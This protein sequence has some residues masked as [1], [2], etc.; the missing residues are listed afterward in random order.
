MTISD[1]FAGSFQH[2]KARV[3]EEF[4][5]EYLTRVMLDVQGCVSQAAKRAGKERRAFGK[6]LK[7]HGIERSSF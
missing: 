2:A 5:R 1:R 7:K 6:L 4:E 3:I